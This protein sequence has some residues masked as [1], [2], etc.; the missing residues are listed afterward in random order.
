MRNQ[1][2]NDF[3]FSFSNEIKIPMREMKVISIAVLVFGLFGLLVYGVYHSHYQRKIS[4]QKR[5]D[6]EAV[7]KVVKEK[8]QVEKQSE[9][10]EVLIE[11]PKESSSREEVLIEEPKES[12]SPAKT[13]A[14][15]SMPGW[16]YTTLF[17][18]LWKMTAHP[19]TLPYNSASCRFI[20]ILCPKETKVDVLG[21]TENLYLHANHVHLEG[22]HFILTQYPY[23]NQGRLFWQ[24]SREACLILD[25]TND[26]DMA[27]GLISYAP[28]KGHTIKFG[29]G[30]KDVCYSSMEA[31][32]GINAKLYT[33]KLEEEGSDPY[34]ISRLHY[35]DWDDHM[36]ITEDDLDRIIAIFEQ[37][38]TDPNIPIMIHCRAGVGRS[39]TVAVVYALHQLIKQNKVDVSNL[40]LH[41]N[42]L[43]LEARK[44]RG[45]GTVQTSA[46]LAAIYRWAWR[47]VH[48]AQQ[49]S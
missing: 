9:R 41:I 46:Q 17:A 35:E 5:E 1:L 44:Q 14:I 34:L 10:G 25:L 30:A 49:D 29:S 18:E 11:E 27:K 7:Q 21:N 15:P 47:A 28:L 36:G 8:F 45:E 42:T 23:Q 19:P 6:E 40:K 16:N 12:S 38:Q 3:A 20:D 37:Y 13:K 4:V 2:P 33:Y 43:I 48:R 24:A 31:L 22:L 26:K 32:D 39:G